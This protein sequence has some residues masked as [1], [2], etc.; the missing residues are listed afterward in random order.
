MTQVTTTQTSKSFILVYSSFGLQGERVGSITI[1][2]NPVTRSLYAHG[3]VALDLLKAVQAHNAELKLN[4]Q[5]GLIRIQD[6]S[7]I[8]I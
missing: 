8:K 5:K 4:K 1:A 2:K 7:Y 6:R 3:F